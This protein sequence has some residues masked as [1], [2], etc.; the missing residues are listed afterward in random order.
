MSRDDQTFI[1]RFSGI[2]IGLVIFTVL[3]IVLAVSLQGPEDPSDNPSQMRLAEERI[4]PVA[5]VRTGD[6][7]APE[8][9]AEAD[10]VAVASAAFDGSLDGQLIYDNVCSACHNAG[11][12]GAPMLGENMAQRLEEKGLEMLVSNAINGIG[13]MPARGG[14]NDLTDEQVRAAVEHMVQ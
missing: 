4:K 13:V 6:M 9:D 10:E 14:R 12:A 7:P 2:I 5:T 11:V 3:I 1:R 8:I